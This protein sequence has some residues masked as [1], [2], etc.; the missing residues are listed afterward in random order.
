M[1][2]TLFKVVAIILAVGVIAFVVQESRRQAR[3]PAPTPTAASVSVATS[4]SVAA[5]AAQ[6]DGGPADAPRPSSTWDILGPATK[7]DPHVVKRAVDGLVPA[8]S[9]SQVAP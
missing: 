2:S 4:A 3:E 8:P 7:A 5:P 9:A 6:K 1:R